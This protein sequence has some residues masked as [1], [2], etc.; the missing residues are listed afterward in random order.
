MIVMKFGGTAI[1]DRT[2][3]E[4][5]AD[6]VLGRLEQRPIVVVSALAGVTDALLTMAQD[7]ASG[8]L[9]QALDLLGQIRE[10]HL[11]VSSTLLREA[12]AS[13]VRERTYKLTDALQDMLRGV[14]TLGELTGRTT[15]AI[16]ATGE[17]LSSGIVTAALQARGIRA[18]LVD[19]RECIVTDATHTRA[20]PL[21]EPTIDRLRQ[22]IEPLVEANQVVVMGGFIAATTRGVTTTLGRGGSDFSAA[23]IG[24]ALDA[25]RIEI[26]TDVEGMMTTDPRLCPRAQ[27]IDAIGFD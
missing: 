1:E 17:L 20:V 22:E 10:R 27:R 6:I 21:F 15:D 12:E 11:E 18:V 2:A 16:L 13:T 23:I 3:I 9:S 14:A 5:A 8:L 7:A 4:R 26:W 24:A 25:S 19:S